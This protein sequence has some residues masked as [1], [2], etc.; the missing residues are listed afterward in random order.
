MAR[1]P[2][3]TRTITTTVVKMLGMDLV[4]RQPVE[5]EVTLAR[6]Y[7]DDKAIMKVLCKEYDTD[8]FKVTA[9]LDKVEQSAIYGMA[10]QDFIAMASILNEDRKIAEQEQEQE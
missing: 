2:M 4:N 5:Q 7:K 6:T 8:E 1:K 3:V 9:I 10:E